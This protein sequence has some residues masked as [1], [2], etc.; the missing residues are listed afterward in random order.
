VGGQGTGGSL[1][2]S[3]QMGSAGAEAGGAAGTDGGGLVC[4]PKDSLPKPVTSTLQVQP[5]CAPT[6]ACESDLDGTEWA[7][8]NVCLDQDVIF[9]PVYGQCKTSKLNGPADIVVDGKLSLAGGMATHEVTISTTG[10]FQI[11]AE[12]ASCDCKGEQ[13]LLKKAGAGPNTY[14]Y[15]DCYPDSSCRCLID[16]KTSVSQNEAYT[17]SGG[18]LT[19]QSGKKYDVC[20]DAAT[21]SLTEKGA[22]PA[23]AGTAQLIPVKATETPEICDG[24]DNDK[25]GKVD[26][27]PV[28]CPP[29]PCD[30]LGVCQ[31]VK[32]VCNGSWVCDY[33]AVKRELGDEKTCDGLDNDCDGEVDEKLVGCFEICDGLDND[34]N[35]KFDDNP[36][37]SPCSATQ[38]VCATGA[39]STCLGK[40]GWRCDYAS[41]KYEPQEVSCDGLDNDCDGQADEGCGCATG[42]SKLFVAHWGATPELVRA[43]LDGTNVEPIP[44]LSGF[45]LTHVA[46][47]SKNNRL[48]FG[49]ATDKIQSANLDGS[50]IKVEWTGKAQ[51]WD[52]NLATGTLLGECNTS[53]VCRL[54]P[55]TTYTTLFQPASV[56]GLDVDPV[57]R[58]LYWSDYGVGA[59]YYIRRVGFDGSNQVDVVKDAQA[60]LTVKV[61]PAGQR[62]YWPNGYGI[63]QA[64]LDGSNEVLWLPLSGVYVYA[65]E[66]DNVGGK[67]YFSDVNAKQVRR[68]GLD[69]KNNELLIKDI[70]YAVSMSLYLCP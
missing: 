49:D 62:I 24:I 7:Y 17:L 8:S 22:A 29:M 13:D 56:A 28:D 64:H 44:A 20:G 52:V 26:D 19:L 66:I 46:V 11:P 41:P 6:T 68:V 23:V 35:G 18:T 43:N 63:Y 3:S 39:T 60:A 67:M 61:D 16:F 51:T 58:M 59:N 5:T 27:D 21:L 42:T 34:N 1:G 14:C 70:D 31:G 50:N 38:G 65:M 45:A 10:V 2:G 33:S 9:A 55:P 48:Y 36:Q 54:A 57:N 25:N 40:A 69:A 53:N 47:D 30:N 4:Q 37:G 32:P 15:P 12:C